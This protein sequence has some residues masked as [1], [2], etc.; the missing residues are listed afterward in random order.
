M[1]SLKVELASLR[2]VAERNRIRLLE[3]WICRSLGEIFLNLGGNQVDEAEQWVRKS[4]EVDARNGMRLS[5][6]MNYGLY[7]KFFKQQGDKSRA[8]EELGKA[9]EILKECGADGLVEPHGQEPVAPMVRRNPPKLQ[10]SFAKA[11]EDTRIPPRSG[12]RGF[13]RRRVMKHEEEMANL[14]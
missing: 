9:I 7:G 3:S 13:L 5:L 14:K 2:T 11:S 1:A 10:S 6:A 12:D 4:I 8:R